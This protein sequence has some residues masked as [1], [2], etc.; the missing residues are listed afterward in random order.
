MKNNDD[1]YDVN[2]DDLIRSFEVSIK[3][4][5]TALDKDGFSESGVRLDKK[6]QKKMRKIKR[7]LEVH[8]SEFIH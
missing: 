1:K 7:K 8:L 5:T 2:R 6:I 3:A 4:T